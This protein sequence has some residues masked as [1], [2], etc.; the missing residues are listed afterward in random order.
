MEE[1]HGH[2]FSNHAKMG[3]DGAALFY[4]TDDLTP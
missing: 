3:Y 1:P 4:R 2:F